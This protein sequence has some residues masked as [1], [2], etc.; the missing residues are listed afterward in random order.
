MRS[1]LN[2]SDPLIADVVVDGDTVRGTD[3]CGRWSCNFV[4]LLPMVPRWVSLW[5]EFK[6][7]LGDAAGVVFEQAYPGAVE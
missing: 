7:H 3:H 4:G 6:L 5:Q 2:L 1:L